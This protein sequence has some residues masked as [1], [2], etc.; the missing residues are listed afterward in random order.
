FGERRPLR[1]RRAELADRTSHDEREGAE[2]AQVVD[3]PA[4]DDA[5]GAEALLAVAQPGGGLPEG[6]A[7]VVERAAHADRGGLGVGALPAGAL[8]QA[9]DVAEDLAGVGEPAAALRALKD[10]LGAERAAQAGGAAAARGR[11]GGGRRG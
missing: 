5:E 11:G 7:E 6:A 10:A 9:H 2:Q 4:L 8:A 1:V 3:L